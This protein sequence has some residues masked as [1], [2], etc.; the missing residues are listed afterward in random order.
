MGAQV[1]CSIRTVRSCVSM[2]VACSALHLS[3]PEVRAADRSAESAAPILIPVVAPSVTCALV[4]DE[5]H[6]LVVGRRDGPSGRLFVYRLDPDG[7]PGAD[8]PAQVDLPRPDPLESFRNYPL[9]LVFHPSLPLLYV[10]QDLDCPRPDANQQKAIDSSFDHLQIFAIDDGVLKS[11]AAFGRGR[12]FVHGQELGRMAI[13][14][15]GA[16]IFL[17]NLRIVENGA[18]A[19]GYYDLDEKGMPRPVPLPIEGTRDAYGLP[20]TE[21]KMRAASVQVHEARRWPM[22]WGFVVPSSQVIIFGA[23]NGPAVWDTA[24]RRAAIGQVRVPEVHQDCFITG[25]PALPVV[26]GVSYRGDVAF[27]MDHAGGYLT[28]I[29]RT[30][31]VEGAKFHSP[32]LVIKGNPH[33]LAVG[34]IDS[35][36]LLPLN[37]HGQ[38]SGPAETIAVTNDGNAVGVLA[39]SPRTA[40]LYAFVNKPK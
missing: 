10:W 35:V 38:F 12:A 14:P 16:R 32:P 3:L 8:E 26:Y 24:S 9:D 2:I 39:W 18:A 30:V 21:L 27:R 25:H 7:I 29:P 19:I 15:A 6:L 1:K 17:S 31:R 22:G 20:R 28:M 37:E 23:W 34:G 4:S 11:A 36:N 13:G 40:R 5:H 33:R